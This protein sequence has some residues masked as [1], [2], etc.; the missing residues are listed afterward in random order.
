[1]PNPYQ[2]QMMPWNMGFQ[3]P[4]GMQQGQD[5]MLLQQLSQG[6]SPVMTMPQQ[7][8]RTGFENLPGF[9][10]PGL[11]GFAMN[12]FVAPMMQQQMSRQGMI[13]G[14][15]SSQ[16]M[17]D[18][19]QNQQFQT[20][21]QEMLRRVAGDTTQAGVVDFF[22]GGA[23]MTGR[24]FD[25]PQRAAARQ[26]GA[27][28]A[29]FAPLLAQIMPEQ[30]DA[31][32]GRRGSAVVMAQ[33][34][35]NTNRFRVDPVTGLM[36][37]DP[38]STEQ[39]FRTLYDEMFADENMANM[40]GVR[41]GEVGG[42]YQELSRRGMIGRD[43]RPT[44][45]RTAEAAAN[46][47]ATGGDAAQTRMLEVLG[48][49]APMAEGG[50]IDF[51]A[52]NPDQ[53]TKLRNQTDVS[54]QLRSF[55]SDKIKSSLEGY[56]D[57]VSTMKEI[58]GEA[59]QTNAPMSKLIASLETLSQGALTQV[60]PGKLNEMIRTTTQLA[61]TSGMSI[62]A[63]LMLQQHSA[64][65]LQNRGI[66]PVM[67][68]QITQG[69]LGFGQAM[70]AQGAFANPAWGLGS[71]DQNR[72][73]D[74][75]LRANA[76]ASP[77]VNAMA[78]VTRGGESVGGYE[79][80]SEA[81]ALAA[82]IRGERTSYTHPTTGEIM[83][84]GDM[85]PDR[86]MGIMAGGSGDMSQGMARSFVLQTAANQEYTFKHGIANTGRR[87]QADQIGRNLY[88]R[89]A[90]NTVAGFLRENDLDAGMAGGIGEAVSDAMQGMTAEERTD[91]TT[92]NQIMAEAIMEASGGAIGEDAARTQ[93]ELMWGNMEQ[94]ISRDPRY[95]GYESMQ[96]LMVQMDPSTLA[97]GKRQRQM[98][99][100][101]ARMK[102]AA[103]GM[104]GGSWMGK[105]VGA[106]EK[107][108]KGK[109]GATIL[110]VLG[111]T[112]GGER[113]KEIRDVMQPGL[114]EL[115]ASKARVKELRTEFANSPPGEAR[116]RI[117][118]QL[119][120]EIILYESKSN[121]LRT[122][123]EENGL[124]DQQAA[125][126]LTDIQEQED[127]QT[128]VVENRQKVLKDLTGGDEELTTRME[129]LEADGGGATMRMAEKELRAKNKE[130]LEGAALDPSFMKK[131]GGR[132]LRAVQKM[133]AG[134]RTQ[135]RLS[136]FFGGDAALQSVGLVDKEGQADRLENLVLA[137]Q[138]SLFDKEGQLD[139][140]FKG[141]SVE[142]LT[143]SE[144]MAKT[145]EGR[146]HRINLGAVNV[147]QQEQQA[148]LDIEE[149][150]GVMKGALTGG[151]GF[152]LE[153][154][155]GVL[156]ALGIP[157]DAELT[158][159][160]MTQAK[161]LQGFRNAQLGVEGAEEMSVEGVKEIADM[162]WEDESTPEG[163]EANKVKAA[164]LAEK[165]GVPE[166]AIRKIARL[167]KANEMLGG[168]GK[169]GEKTIRKIQRLEK[170]VA[171]QRT[172]EKKAEV[173]K[174]L[175][176]EK[177]KLKEQHEGPES[178]DQL[179]SAV[180]ERDEHTAD[181]SDRAQKLA[182]LDP[183]DR[184]GAL[185]ASLGLT[186]EAS[187]KSLREQ[188]GSY[189][190]TDVGSDVIEDIT[191]AAQSS[192]AIIGKAGLEDKVAYGAIQ[193]AKKEGWTAE[194]L[195]TELGGKV[196]TEQASQLLRS[197]GVLKKSGMLSGLA[198]GLTGDDLT[199]SITEN[200]ESLKETKMSSEDLKEKVLQIRGTVTLK[201]QTLTLSETEGTQE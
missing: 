20:Q 195:S 181:L 77:L 162:S 145:E 15:L 114:V 151:A 117:G 71:M 98:G 35:S 19:T 96:N 78:A 32:S 22:R 191:R 130:L 64:G 61:Q 134:L 116:D 66:N 184:V 180:A 41:A 144:V 185:G 6:F 10:S 12:S 155:G 97:L 154:S 53:M 23:E 118:K 173:Q 128:N 90:R 9:N 192:S 85:T 105:L 106:V 80:G 131:A 39:Q 123:A 177:A 133:E 197:G 60:N 82:A 34:M 69:G 50:G 16:N 190:Q 165:H 176:A 187:V 147:E 146:Q 138:G 18:Y 172:P 94:K 93:A 124:L 119:D 8:M 201:G 30:L 74:I 1:M 5:L 88:Q 11:M 37:M 17:L 189:G 137:E 148:K 33:K 135:T 125:L 95:Q 109:A 40:R 25:A 89:T 28:A 56:V 169:E 81:A 45:L 68:S 196:T 2:Q 182:R 75:N 140:R 175:D 166:S 156:D 42:M 87:T 186:D 29:T 83:Q 163:I 73:L 63:A 79:E 21:Q 120:E 143:E 174:L 126:D 36:G 59:G 55:D 132:G 58:F 200:L 142:G 27:T 150:K 54:T 48:E 49:E 152:L 112:V 26:I 47:W 86:M 84:I 62:D 46:V 161:R 194:K 127:A 198:D 153:P 76:A 100:F 113:A 7:Q 121:E 164:A 4:Y 91:R 193:T 183:G 171:R 136:S 139:P 129:L 13:P 199:E 104:T 170:R 52:L 14:G 99:G 38:E 168:L 157:R 70:G 102:N 160:E 57:V 167:G 92:R 159:A 122:M 44:H 67:A 158:D 101:E 178:V 108:G 141:T 188:F 72:Q 51:G 111:E 179:M 115:A 31:M 3:N 65:A 110:D 103:A 24:E 43:T 149:A 107:A